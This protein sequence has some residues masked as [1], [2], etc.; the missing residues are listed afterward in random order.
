MF[1]SIVYQLIVLVS[2]CRIE[3]LHVVADE[4]VRLEVVNAVVCVVL[5]CLMCLSIDSFLL[6]LSVHI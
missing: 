1:L 4:L 2:R 3:S 5:L 6:L